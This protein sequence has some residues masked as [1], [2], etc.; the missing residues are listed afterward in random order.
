M[1][2]AEASPAAWEK[3]M[4]ARVMP[5]EGLVSENAN[6]SVPKKCSSTVAAA[7]LNVAWAPG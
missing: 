6:R 3:L 1:R 5:R 4:N 7:W 2:L